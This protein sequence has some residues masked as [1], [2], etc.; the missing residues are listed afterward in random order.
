MDVQLH[1][2]QR[3]NSYYSSA[4]MAITAGTAY[5]T[6]LDSSV[7]VPTASTVV[8]VQPVAQQQF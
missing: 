6:K 4:L 2:Q 3:R 8:T 1:L 7:A 5:S